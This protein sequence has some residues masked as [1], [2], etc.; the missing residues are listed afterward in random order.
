M[1]AATADDEPDDDADEDELDEDEAL[2][3]ETAEL[4]DAD[5]AEA[6]LDEEVDDTK[7]CGEAVPPPLSPPHPPSETLKRVAAMDIA[8]ANRDA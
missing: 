5:D 4:A 1:V 6:V 7:G 8:R 3:E 2:D